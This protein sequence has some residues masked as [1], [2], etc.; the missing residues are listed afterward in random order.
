MNEE[1]HEKEKLSMEVKL[2]T[3]TGIEH[4]DDL[5]GHLITL[6]EGS[7][8]A[9]I[10]S[11]YLGGSYS[12]GTA[13]GHDSS[14]N[15]S[16]VDLFVI[17]RGTVTEDENAT[18]EH[19]VAE[20]R[21]DL[22]VQ[23][24]A[25][26]YSEDD[27]FG[28]L[29]KDATQ[30]SFLNVLIKEVGVLVYGDDLRADLPSV[31]FSRYVLD[32]IE[33]GVFH[34]GIPHQREA[35]AYPLVTPLVPP[36]A[37]P[38][39]DGEFYGYD[40]VPARPD[41]PHGTRVFVALTAWIATLILALETGHYAGQKS[42]SQRLC[43]EYLP[44]DKR[45]Q[46]AAEILDFCKGSWGYA[47][48][49]SVEGRERL[50]GLCRETLFLENEYLRI[51]HNYVLAQLQHAPMQEKRQALRILQSVVYRD[52]EIVIVLKTL[53][54]DTDETVQAGAAKALEVLEHNT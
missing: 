41:A 6:C 1:D 25:H 45:T 8:P 16:D 2:H 17:F 33:S 40:V 31:P 28:L 35:L 5:L 37:Y 21:R 22:P 51:V 11:Y 24:D 38:N 48:P 43:K 42:Q 49:S 20:C 47:Q 32:V 14:P 10:R 23:V 44:H 9:R 13:V 30:T 12:D 19:L 36:L 3:T 52:N 29:R 18:F 34:V 50:R 15:S 39:P 46:L 7:F 27:L 26:A 53:V 4:L 54:R